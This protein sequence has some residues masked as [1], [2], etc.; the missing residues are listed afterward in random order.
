MNQRAP[1]KVIPFAPSPREQR[2]TQADGDPID[3]SGAAIVS[4]LQEAVDVAK[5][6]CERAMDIAH[7]L[8]LQLRA[9]EDRIAQLEGEIHHYQE[10]AARAEKWMHRIHSEIEDRFFKDNPAANAPRR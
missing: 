9:A 4:M 10:R 2:Q 8:S 7:K 1:E 5:L 3:R 6:N